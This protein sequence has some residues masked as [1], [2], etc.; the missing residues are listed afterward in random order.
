MDADADP[1]FVGMK[2]DGTVD[3]FE[4]LDLHATR[5]HPLWRMVT[6][7]CA[8]V[9]APEESRLKLVAAALYQQNFELLEKLKEVVHADPRPGFIPSDN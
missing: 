2:E 4:Y 6:A 1:P 8:R 5:N 7:T 9:G 3:G